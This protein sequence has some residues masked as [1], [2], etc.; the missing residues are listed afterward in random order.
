[1]PFQA[2]YE[3]ARKVG[4]LIHDRHQLWQNG[5]KDGHSA[6]RLRDLPVASTQKDDAFDVVGKKSPRFEAHL[7]A[8]RVAKQHARRIPEVRTH[9]H[10]VPGVLRDI[11]FFG[12]DRRPAS[13][14]S[15]VMPMRNIAVSGDIVP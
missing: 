6:E 4:L 7:R 1:M 2:G 10:E 8:H 11:D 15:A 9:G 14:V 3:R 5:V 13:A 12:V